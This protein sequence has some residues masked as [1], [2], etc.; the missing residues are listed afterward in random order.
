MPQLFIRFQTL[1]NQLTRAPPEDEAKAVF[2]AALREP[3]RTMCGVLDFRMSTMDQ[4]IDRVLEMDKHSSFMSLGVLHRALPKEEDLRF[5]QA[6]QCTTCLNSSH[7]MVDCTMRTQCMICHSRAHTTDRCEYNLLNQRKGVAKRQ[8][9]RRSPNANNSWRSIPQDGAQK[10][11]NIQTKG[12]PA[13]NRNWWEKERRYRVR[14][15]AEQ[16]NR[17]KKVRWCKSQ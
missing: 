4:V 15:L 16:K 3:L 17:L 1:H 12:H 8:H 14:R 11:K 13:G 2:L 7:S 6:L 10:T 5:R 9:R